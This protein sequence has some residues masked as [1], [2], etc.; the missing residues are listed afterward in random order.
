MVEYPEVGKLRDYG[1]A[2][3]FVITVRKGE[4]HNT[5][6]EPGYPIPPCSSL[7]QD[8]HQ[9]YRDSE[10]IDFCMMVLC[11]APSYP[12]AFSAL[13]ESLFVPSLQRS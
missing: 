7:Y 3:Y 13:T 4:V 9:S 8:V 2:F 12:C 11:E 10:A 6:D 1:L 5:G